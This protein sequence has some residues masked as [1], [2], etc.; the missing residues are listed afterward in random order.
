MQLEPQPPVS[1]AGRTEGA[2]G[3]YLR[4][5][6]GH[7]LLVLLLTLAAL[8]AALGWLLLSSSE[9]QA[10]AQIL[11]TPLPQDA[12][13]ALGLPLLR[14]SSEPTRVVQ[15]AA[16]LLRSPEA[17]DRT[18]RVLGPAW[19]RRTVLEAVTIEPQGE[20]NIVAITATAESPTLAAMIANSYAQ[21]A[22]DARRNLLRR[23]VQGRIAEAEARRDAL[24]G[25]GGEAAAEV[26]AVLSQLESIRTGGDPTLLMSQ[27]AVPPTAS[28]GAPPWL[29]LLLALLGGFT[30][31][32][33]VALLV[34]YLD[35][36]VRDE[37]ELLAMWPLPILAHIP[38]L[39][40][41][42]RKR[43]EY[44]VLSSPPGIREAFR[45]AQV[46]LAPV[47]GGSR[48]IMV[49]SAS[50]GD[51]KTTSATNLAV[52]MVGAGHKVILI[53]FDVRRPD[54]ARLLGV[55]ESRGLAALL[56]SN[57]SLTDLLVPAPE[58]PALSVVPAGTQGDVVLLEALSRRLPEVLAQAREVADYVVVDTA[59][60]GEV[61][62][63][64]R[65]VDHVDDIIFV[66]RPGHTARAGLEL[67][68]DLLARTGH[69]PTGQLVM[70]QT[71]GGTSVYYTYGMQ[72][73]HGRRTLGVAAA[74]STRG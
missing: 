14:E 66:T 16:T 27:R 51:G 47:S 36:R 13:A 34:E 21:A 18:A 71:P 4:A 61:S 62:D 31:A 67:T 26:A 73:Q 42:Q 74:R 3:P 25:D 12:S 60:L 68:R 70:G 9:Y 54:I 55:G 6:V 65:L 44:S 40:R 1:P 59:P 38:P 48:V 11:V 22:L 32:M 45:T 39:P 28:V 56:A 35:R 29:V 20:S 37:D 63:A 69:E 41:R 49:T 15:T 5:L 23:Q 33:G 64:L 19:S 10:D 52:A 72:H 17:A 2:L 24:E 8:G 30:I 7:R 43:G 46:Q 58:L 57:T 53:D 50:T